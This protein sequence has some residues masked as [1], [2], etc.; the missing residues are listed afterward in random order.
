MPCR[1]SRPGTACPTA[2]GEEDTDEVRERLLRM[3]NGAAPR[4]HPPIVPRVPV[5]PHNAGYLLPVRMARCESARIPVT[6][7]GND[8]VRPLIRNAGPASCRLVT[9][10]ELLDGEGEV[11]VRWGSSAATQSGASSGSTVLRRSA[12]EMSSASMEMRPP[13]LRCCGSRVQ[14]CVCV[15]GRPPAAQ[16]WASAE[17]DR[18]RRRA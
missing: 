14:P 15:D 13:R 10:G 6:V 7:R 8:H 5:D 9:R 12:G 11:A 18:H 1:P 17:G 2:S 4:R 16:R 3:E